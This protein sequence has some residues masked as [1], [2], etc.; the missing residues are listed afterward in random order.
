MLDWRNSEEFL[1]DLE[2]ETGVTPKALL[3]RPNVT[4]EMY[5]YTWAFTILSAKRNV[6]IVPNP[7]YLGDI[8]AFIDLFGAPL[9]GNEVFIKLLAQMDN[10]FLTKTMEKDKK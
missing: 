8:K 6:G 3:N 9:H 1:E 2:S 5:E 10:H 7:I 4:A